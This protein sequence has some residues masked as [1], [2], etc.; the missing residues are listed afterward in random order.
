MTTDAAT[1]G[2]SLSFAYAAA[3]LLPRAEASGDRLITALYLILKAHAG[4]PD[5]TAA[6]AELTCAECRP[7]A[8]GEREAYPC[9]TA[10][11]AF[12]ALDAILR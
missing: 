12:W 1:A 11:Q 7:A 2:R 3:A 6:G 5:P 10:Q 8:C 9:R 4:I